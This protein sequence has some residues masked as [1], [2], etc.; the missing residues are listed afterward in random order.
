MTAARVGDGLDA[1]LFDL[2]G[3]LVDS[4]PTIARA[5]AA[6]CR[7]HGY[8]VDAEAVIPIIGAQWPTWR[9]G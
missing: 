1:I 5:M 9:S 6:A 4:L 3:T 2:D 8:E 7:E